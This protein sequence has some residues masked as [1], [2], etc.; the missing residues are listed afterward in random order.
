MTQTVANQVAGETLEEIAKEI[1]TLSRCGPIQPDGV[2][3]FVTN[4]LRE[5]IVEALR[6]ERERC[7]KLLDVRVIEISN[8]QTRPYRVARREL[9][10]SARAIR[11][12]R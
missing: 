12:G 3:V 10:V 6:N 11:E 7:A 2:A 9:E 4:V 1:V 8:Y 5:R